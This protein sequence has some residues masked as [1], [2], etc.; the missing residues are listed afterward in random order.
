[1]KKFYLFAILLFVFS[2]C[3][4]RNIDIRSL[5][6]D[7][8]KGYIMFAR[9]KVQGPMKFTS[10]IVEYFPSSRT[11]KYASFLKPNQKSIYEVEPGVHYFYLKNGPSNEMIKVDVSAGRIYYLII[12]WDKNKDVIGGAY[13][14]PLKSSIVSSVGHLPT[15]KIDLVHKDGKI[16]KEDITESRFLAIP[17]RRY[18]KYYK[19]REKRFNIDAYKTYKRIKRKEELQA[20]EGFD[21]EF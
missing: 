8:S 11:T 3:S 20:K 10:K 16:Y 19:K 18:M 14:N 6:D 12:S 4:S 7:E 5:A 17:P 2:G 13:F 9:Q 1:M 21:I 15:N